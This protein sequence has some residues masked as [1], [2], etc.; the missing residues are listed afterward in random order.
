ME[1]GSR[2]AHDTPGV[3]RRVHRSIGTQERNL[4]WDSSCV[5]SADTG[6]YEAD[7]SF[8]WLSGYPQ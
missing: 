2:E 3:E 5:A 4:H 8:A 6:H 7:F 1:A